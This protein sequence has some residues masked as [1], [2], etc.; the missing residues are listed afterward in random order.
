MADLAA[1]LFASIAAQNDALAAKYRAMTTEEVRALCLAEA[2]Q[3][4]VQC[5]PTN[6]GEAV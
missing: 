2:R 4:A 1:L 3:V 5:D 6:P